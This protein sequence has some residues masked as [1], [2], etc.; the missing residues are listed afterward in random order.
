MEKEFK[1][2]TWSFMYPHNTG[3]ARTCKDCH[4]S[5]KTVGLGYGSL[6]YLGKGRFRFTPAEAPSE[7]LEIEHGL[8]AVVDLSGKP[9]V[10][11]RPGVRGFNG[12]E[13]RQILRVGLCLSCH[14]DF[15]DPV[16]RNWPPRKPCPVF[17]E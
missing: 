9:L 1:R 11:F 17:K 5:A 7:L 15:S 8:S 2:I 10:N 16:M 6:T 3:K 4:Q 14:R 12:K 13:I